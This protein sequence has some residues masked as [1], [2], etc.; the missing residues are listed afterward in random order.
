MSRTATDS[1]PDHKLVRPMLALAIISAGSGA[2]DLLTGIMVPITARHFTDNAAI[3]G[4]MLAANRLFGFL[5]QP[6]VACRSDQRRSRFGRRRAWLLV[7]Y[8]VTLLGVLM[9]GAIPHLL[10]QG[11]QTLVWALALVFIA[12]LLMQAFLDV[13][14]GAL[15]P[16]YG[17]TFRAERLGRAGAWRNYAGMA[18]SFL[19]FYLLI[20]LADRHEFIPY[21]GV[22]VL[23]LLS[24][25]MAWRFRED[26]G[27]PLAPGES[28][29]PWKPLLR[30]R[31][32]KLRH[33]ATIAAAV[34]GVSAIQ[35]MF[36]SLFVTETLGLSKTVLGQATLFSMAVGVVTTY[37]CG[38]LLDRYGARPALILGFLSSSIFGLV[39]AFLVHDRLNLY[40]VSALSSTGG[41]LTMMAMTPLIYRFAPSERRGEFFGSVQA[42][43]AAAATVLT[44]LGGQL[45]QWRGDYRTTYLFGVFIAVVGL[46]FTWKLPAQQKAAPEPC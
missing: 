21:L 28:F 5:V 17:D 10:P 12:N 37:P 9:L 38:L 33:I 11:A 14:Y 26:P 20:P 3:I 42:T 27:L 44:L 1:L 29:T 34:L 43:R 46:W 40:I 18:M 39:S 32:P 36:H 13:T 2:V 45:T 4:V 30:L 7:G 41:M 15:D 23:L 8:P 22:A 19:M 24:W 6:Y 16:L 31:D 35:G 25:F